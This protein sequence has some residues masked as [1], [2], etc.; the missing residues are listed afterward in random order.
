M[1][2]PN[3]GPPPQGGWNQP[4]PWQPQGQPG[5]QHPPGTSTPPRSAAIPRLLVPIAAGIIAL[6]VIGL[7]LLSQSSSSGSSVSGPQA[8]DCVARAEDDSLDVVGCGST[9]AQYRVVGAV[10]SNSSSEALA[11][12]KQ[13]Y[14]KVTASYFQGDTTLEPG[15]ALCLVAN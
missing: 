1:S 9:D 6:S 5:P 11:A 3:D 8:G 10:P 2:T 7:F 12:C 15:N 14:P 13:A 4:G